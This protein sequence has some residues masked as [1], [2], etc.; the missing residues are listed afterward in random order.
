[1]KIFILEDEID[2]YPRIQIREVLERKHDLTIARSCDDAIEKFNHPYDLLLLDH[3][4]EGN[5]EYRTDYPNTGY[6]F[7]KWL[8]AH[9]KAYGD[10]NNWVKP[11]VI[12]HSHNPVGK[13]NMR[14]LLAEH[15]FS[16]TVACFGQAY[17]KQLKEQLG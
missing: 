6:Q 3:D 10:L 7:L 13:E 17:V 9:W 1:M 15:G 4:M 11:Q 8:M 16:V 12:L 14:A 2:F 5:Y